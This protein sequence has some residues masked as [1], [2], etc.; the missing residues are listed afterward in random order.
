MLAICSSPN[1]FCLFPL[2]KWSLALMKRTSSSFLHFFRT[3]MQT[4][5][6]VVWVK[7]FYTYFQIPSTATRWA[8]LLQR[9]RDCFVHP[10]HL[11]MGECTKKPPHC[12]LFGLFALYS[13]WSGKAPCPFK[14]SVVICGEFILWWGIGSAHPRCLEMGECTKKPP[15]SVRFGLFAFHGHWSGIA[16]WHFK[17]SV[18]IFGGFF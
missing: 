6:P 13:H 11:K 16:P 15:H 3:R 17:E 14:K 4:G 10:C 7:T 12:F 1:V 8:L 2:V 18:E 9:V 5:I